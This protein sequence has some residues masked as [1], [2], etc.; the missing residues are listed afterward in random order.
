MDQLHAARVTRLWVENKAGYDF[1]IQAENA[2][3]TSTTGILPSNNFT[4]WGNFY[5][6]AAEDYKTE[7]DTNPAFYYYDIN[8]DSYAKVTVTVIKSTGE[9]EVQETGKLEILL[10]TAV[11]EDNNLAQTGFTAVINRNGQIVVFSY[12]SGQ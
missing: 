3:S 12:R 4:K 8:R 6:A 7:R 2:T 10:P 9:G 1:N 5:D 11:G